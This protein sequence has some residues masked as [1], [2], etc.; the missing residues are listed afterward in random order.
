M[1]PSSVG[2]GKEAIAWSI[3]ALGSPIS[4]F[5]FQLSIFF[6]IFN[7]KIKGKLQFF[8]DV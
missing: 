5:N 6:S 1:V 2:H 8:E 7:C 4:S 3:P